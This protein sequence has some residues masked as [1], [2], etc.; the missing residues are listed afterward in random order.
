MRTTETAVIDD[1][2]REILLR[3]LGTDTLP[4]VVRDFYARI[5]RALDRTRGFPDPGMPL[6]FAACIVAMYEMRW[7]AEPPPL[8]EQLEEITPRHPASYPRWWENV[9]V[10]MPVQLRWNGMRSG[11][12][13]GVG[14]DGKLRVQIQCS[15]RTKIISTR[16]KRVRLLS[17]AKYVEPTA[18]AS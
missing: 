11:T 5:Q 6:I 13:L 18:K 10:G 14:P 4:P 9:P 3:M 7:L 15:S 17:P 16:A 8:P 1:Q 2:T 12:Y